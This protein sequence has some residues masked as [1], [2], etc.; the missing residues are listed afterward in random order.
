MTV[1]SFA[2]R[3]IAKSYDQQEARH[4]RKTDQIVGRAKQAL[5]APSPETRR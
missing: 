3:V 1:P 5:G 2:H 4:G